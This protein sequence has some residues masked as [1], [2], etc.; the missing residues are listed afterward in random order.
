MVRG[1]A[2]RGGG[3]APPS[4]SSA[5]GTAAVLVAHNA[6]F[7]TSFLQQAAR[8]CRTCPTDFTAIDTVIL[9]RSLFPELKKHKLDTRGQAP[10]TGRLQPPPRLRRRA[11]CS[12]EIFLRMLRHPESGEGLQDIGRD[13][14]LARG[15][16]REEMP[17]PTTRSFWSKTS[18]GS[19][20]STAWSPSSHLD[21]YF[22]AIR[23]SPN[24]S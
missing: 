3:A 12:H 1:R 14:H 11:R 19:K 21:Y 15:G 17:L 10:R 6:P 5:A 16:R 4:T 24:A 18:R 2:L 9:S 13:Q 8:R 23:A 22:D 7:D 20:T